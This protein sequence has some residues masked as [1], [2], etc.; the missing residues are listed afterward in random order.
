[1]R[2]A[3]A[4]RSSLVRTVF[5]G[6][7]SFAVPILHALVSRFDVE[8]VGV[9]APPD[10]RVGRTGR[11]TAVPVATAARAVGLPLLQV[12]RVRTPEAIDAI[13]TLAPD[14]GVLADFGQ[15]VPQEILD[16]PRL[17]ILNVHPSLLP[18]HRGATPIQAT[19]LAGDAVAGVSIMRMD[20][21]LDTGPVLAARSWVLDGT[22]DTPGLELR[23]AREGASLLDQVVTDVLAGRDN[24]TPQEPAAAT[25]TRPLVREAG[26]LD[27]RLPAVQLERR[28]RAMRPWPGTFL[29][30]GRLRLVVHEVAIADLEPGDAP[31]VLAAAGD[32][33]ALPT[34]DA[35]IVL[36]RVQPAGGREMTGAALR[37][38]RPSIIGATVASLPP[39]SPAVE[40]PG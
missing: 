27:P 21:G 14:L 16:L 20:A 32:G 12:P 8:L 4:G 5:F 6:S 37:R 19:I 17:G 13:R 24:G 15:L 35:R 38:G 9:V 7:G 33:I 1:M 11:S 40:A 28:V 26:R 31:G 23:A 34:V 2:P 39:V 22:E 10:G 18:R 36:R 29:E 30:V 3:D 25:M